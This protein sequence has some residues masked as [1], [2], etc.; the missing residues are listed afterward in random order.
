[1]GVWDG[2]VEAVDDALGSLLGINP[3]VRGLRTGPGGRRVEHMFDT[4]IAPAPGLESAV[5][6]A[7]GALQGLRRAGEELAEAVAR[8]REWSGPQRTAFLR[9]LDQVAGVLATARS[10][11][12]VAEQQAGTSLAPGDRDF[13]AARARLMRSGY[14]HAAREVA[15]ATTLDAM[16]QVA[17]AVRAGTVPLAHVDA[18]ARVTGAA[19]ESGSAALSSAEGQAAVI[20]LATRLTLKDFSARVAQ[21]AASEDPCSLERDAERQR[22]ARFLHL[23]HQP[24]GTFLRG[25]LD[26][27]DGEI[28][29]AALASTGQAPDETRDKAQADAD[30]LVALAQR[31]S[32][33]SAGRSGIGGIAGS[34]GGRGAPG[35]PESPGRL[36]PQ[37][38]SPATLGTPT[39]RPTR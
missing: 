18:L 29:R 8:C 19:S 33:G 35:P 6:P 20:R 25:R 28:L 31:A 23:S 10:Q 22:A 16:P 26:R 12:L 38:M 14:G 27:V 37:A 17:A 39:A 1:M 5:T 32:A 21:L 24:D 9:A 3:Q 4:L 7:D 15:Q 30:A 34:T 36:G 13:A 2:S 11:L